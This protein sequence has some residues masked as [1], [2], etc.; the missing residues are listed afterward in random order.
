MAAFPRRCSHLYLKIIVLDK[1]MQ[2]SHQPSPYILGFIILDRSYG[3][4]LLSTDFQSYLLKDLGCVWSAI[5][6]IKLR[7]QPGDSLVLKRKSNWT[8]VSDEGEDEMHNGSYDGYNSSYDSD[9]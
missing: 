1:Y 5:R 4:F 3:D 8:I 9:A 6:D 2:V 7:G